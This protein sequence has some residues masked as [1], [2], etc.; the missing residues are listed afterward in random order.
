MIRSAR[1]RPFA[2]TVARFCFDAADRMEVQRTT[3]RC[4]SPA[5]SSTPAIRRRGLRPLLAPARPHAGAVTVG[6]TSLH[7]FDADAWRSTV[8]RAWIWS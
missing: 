6:G 8:P 1:L 7:E 3:A 4:V 5:P 2:I